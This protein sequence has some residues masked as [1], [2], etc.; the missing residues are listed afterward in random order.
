MAGLAAEIACLNSAAIS[1]ELHP[2][3]VC[4]GAD[5]ARARIATRRL[6]SDGAEALVSFGVAGGLDPKLRP[7]TVVLADSVIAPNGVRRACDHDWL[8]RLG[9][10]LGETVPYATAAVF[11]GDEALDSREAKGAVFARHG[12]VAVDLESFAVSE[13]ASAAGAPFVVIRAVADPAERNVP[14]AALAGLTAE[15][16]MAALPV[17]GALRLEPRQTLAVL[18]LALDTARAFRGL[19]RVAARALPDFAF[20]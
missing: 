19:R 14:S 4:S 17:L 16:R 13:T 2:L 5:A 15:G 18:R 20:V 8:C 6:L 9:D 11:G 12:A 7:G 3:M 1:G 10:L